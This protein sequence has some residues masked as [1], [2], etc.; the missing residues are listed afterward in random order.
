VA[1]RE[2]ESARADVDS[3]EAPENVTSMTNTGAGA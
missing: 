3:G 2:A 1:K